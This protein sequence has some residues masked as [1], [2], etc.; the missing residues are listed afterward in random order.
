MAVI[1][2]IR[3]STESQDYNNQR[4]AILDF[5]NKEEMTVEDWYEV[6]ISSRKSTKK[7]RVDEL[8][9]HLKPKDQLIVSELSRLARS[10]GQISI[11]VD[12]L[13]DNDIYLTS[14]KEGIKING[15]MNL[16]TKTMVTM[17][18]LFSEIERDLISERTKEGLRAAK[19]KGK[20]LGR[21]KGGSIL[22][23]KEE[24]IKTELGYGV[25]VSAIARKLGCS[26]GTLIRFIDS[27]KLKQGCN[28][29]NKS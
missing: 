24:L 2:Y 3:V 1:G 28:P 22:E 29:N 19:E 23:G 7:R 27:K 8:L 21:P 6:T 16:Q 12:R 17:F 13:I 10:V 25:A 4:L 5:C 11:I 9:E 14:I 26:R 20:I 18:S 15:R